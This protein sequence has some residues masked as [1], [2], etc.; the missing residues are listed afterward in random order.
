VQLLQLLLRRSANY[1]P[2]FPVVYSRRSMSAI[3]AWLRGLELFL[4]RLVSNLFG[5]VNI[6]PQSSEKRH[7]SLVELLLHFLRVS[8][9]IFLNYPVLFCNVFSKPFYVLRLCFRREK[10]VEYWVDQ[11]MLAMDTATRIFTVL[12]QPDKNFLRQVHSFTFITFTSLFSMRNLFSCRF[13]SPCLVSSMYLQ[14]IVGVMRL[15]LD[16]H[17]TCIYIVCRRT[18]D[19]S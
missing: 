7:V 15:V 9:L 2:S 12:K 3:Q 19:P 8:L 13:L 16:R 5:F 17:E 6:Y 18:L 14:L 4:N 10:F 11:N 1:R